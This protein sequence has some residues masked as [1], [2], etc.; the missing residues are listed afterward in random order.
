VRG[1]QARPFFGPDLTRPHEATV[2]GPIS[3]LLA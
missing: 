1:V 2:P 3:C